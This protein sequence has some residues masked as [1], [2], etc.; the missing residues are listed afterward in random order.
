MI[1]TVNSNIKYLGHSSSDLSILL[2]KGYS[3]TIA[4]YILKQEGMWRIHIKESNCSLM[5][6][7]GHNPCSIYNAGKEQGE[8]DLC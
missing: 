3:Q 6:R 8:L 4:I 7:T 2:F 5:D 1:N